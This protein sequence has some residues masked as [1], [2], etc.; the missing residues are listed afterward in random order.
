M[1]A[2]FIGGFAPPGASSNFNIRAPPSPT[3]PQVPPKD[4]Q[5]PNGLHA[6]AIGTTTSASSG[7]S[8]LRSMTA[9]ERS[10]YYRVVRM[11]PHLQFMAGPLLRYDTVDENGTWYG[12]CMIVSMY[13]STLYLLQNS[14]RCLQ[15]VDAGS[16]YEP[17][18]NLTYEWDAD[19]NM[20]MSRSTSHR[21]GRSIDLG[22]HPADPYSSAPVASDIPATSRTSRKEQVPGH[23][24][25]VYEGS[26]RY[27]V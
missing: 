10:Q 23:E 14:D 19:A 18:P 26:S 8:S 27:D 24:I 7:R 11:N 21:T 1:N 25:W 12:A 6:P 5:Y 16:V 20:Q 9:V 4:G 3:P 13:N 17:H 15:A 22:P 2:G